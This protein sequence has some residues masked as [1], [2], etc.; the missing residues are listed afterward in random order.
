MTVVL[1]SGG[2]DSTVLATDLVRN[3]DTQ[4]DM[5]QGPGS[6][7][8]SAISIDYGQ[9]HVRELAAAD[10]VARTLGIEHRVIDAASVGRG[11][12]S[13]L[14]D[15]DRPVPEGHYAEESMAA[16]VVPGRNLL[17]AAIAIAHAASTG[18]GTVALAV[19]AG[20]HP[21]YPDC[22]PEFTSMVSTLA[23]GTYG[24]RVAAPY[25]RMSKAEICA[26]GSQVGAPLG[27]SWSCYQ[28]GD[29]HCGRCGTCVERAEAFHL[30]K[31]PDPTT[32]AD[33]GY[34][35]EAVAA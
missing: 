10:A 9:R 35:R 24:V 3:I 33:A 31:V 23:E 11:L 20:D 4:R 30:A 14:T 13:A 28:G 27:L 5:W 18:H 21:V 29:F 6:D 12:A 19:H 17:F 15:P 8:V 2:M 25:V 1:L 22:R 26:W 16:T 32:Y 34:W 7:R